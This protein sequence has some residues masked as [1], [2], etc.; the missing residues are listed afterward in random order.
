MA[1]ITA[2]KVIGNNIFAKGTVTAYDNTFKNVAKKFNNGAL[3]GSVYSY[4]SRPDGL[5][6]MVYLNSSDFINQKPSFVK[7]DSNLSLPALPNILAQIS[8]E[9]EAEKLKD[10]GTLQYNIDKYLPYIIGAVVVA[11]ALPTVLNSTKKIGAMKKNNNTN[12]LLIAGGAAALYFLMQKKRK[13][14]PPIVENLPGEFVNEFKVPAEYQD[15]NTN[16]SGSG[17]TIETAGGEVIP[18]DSYMVTNTTNSGGGSSPNDQFSNQFQ[19]EVLLDYVGPF[20][21]QYAAVNGA[22]I[23]RGDMGKLKT[24]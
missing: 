12:L 11:V 23:S 9:L 22:K 1:T 18:V 7:H 21:T 16:D 6:W 24:N 14:L 2:D 3:V 4:V 20:K 19:N 8:K 13:A 15:Y 10:K 5:Y 17:I